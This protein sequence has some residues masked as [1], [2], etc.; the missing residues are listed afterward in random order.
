MSTNQLKE[1]VSGEVARRE[2]TIFEYLERPKTQQGLKAVA[3]SYFTVDRFLRLSINAIRKTPLLAQC[4]PTSVLGAIMTSAALGLEPNT[5]Q[6]QAFLLPFKK[7]APLL[8]SNGKPV[9]GEDGK[10]IWREFYECQ[11]IIGYRGFIT[12]AYRSSFIKSIEAEAIR[13]GDTF[14]HMKGS[15]SFLKYEKTL[16]RRGELMGS[17]CLTKLES[18]IE[19]AT[20][21]P[22][23]EIY[24]IRSK[25]ETYTSLSRKLEQATKEKDIEKAKRALDETP[26]VMWEDDMAAKSAIRKHSKQLPLVPGDQVS[27]AAEIDA[28]AE[29][30]TIDMAAMA[31]PDVVRGVIDDGYEPPAL[32]NDPSDDAPSFNFPK[33]KEREPA[34][35][36]E[37]QP[38][39]RQSRRQTRQAPVTESGFTYD[40]VA[41]DLRGAKTL[42][43]LHA[44]ADQIRDVADETERG[45][46]Q[47][48]YSQR[49][50]EFKGTEDAP[51]PAQAA[52]R[53]SGKPMSME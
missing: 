19:V 45:D 21:L 10:W 4:D 49:Q 42:D 37:R 27:A 43:A 33:E 44:A 46:L 24:K 23:E 25:S 7:S 20:V 35:A 48:I 11:F 14:E 38:A 34:P 13:V 18:G 5:I 6:Q 3:G 2:P 47:H 52:A 26:W 28:R 53:S 30:N 12:L 32:E 1:A 36:Q 41:A 17:W 50:A 39:A 16:R 22:L 51:A 31:D 40:Q 15:T 9:T 29:A 8:G